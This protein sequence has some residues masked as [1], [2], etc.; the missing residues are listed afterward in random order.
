MARRTAAW[1]IGSVL[2]AVLAGAALTAGP[3]RADGD[4]A[5][6]TLIA[7]SVFYPYSTS[8]PAVARRS[9]NRAVAAAARAGAPVKVALIA[10]P[11]D[12][13][14]ITGLWREPQRYADFLH[15]EISYGHPVRLLVVMPLGD[16]AAGFSPGVARA[17]EDAA[18]AGDGSGAALAYAAT[19][20]VQRLTATA[21]RTGDLRSSSSA[22]GR[23]RTVLLL[24]LIL[25]AVLVSGAIVVLRVFFPP[26][27]GRARS[28]GKA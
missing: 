25:A 28:G 14:S 26:P 9:L 8:V 18:P 5:S 17:L 19:R 16:G 23:G 4:P 22:S 21:R 3:S 27:P 20:A 24:V 13:G 11:S 2:A 7:Q 1:L 12:L 10:H 15:T 6:D